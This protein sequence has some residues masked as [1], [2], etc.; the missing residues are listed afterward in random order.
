MQDEVV[1]N[2]FKKL[3]AVCS[4]LLYGEAYRFLGL[5]GHQIPFPNDTTTAGMRRGRT[6]RP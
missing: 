1:I 5:N 2:R 3:R 6:I 4:G